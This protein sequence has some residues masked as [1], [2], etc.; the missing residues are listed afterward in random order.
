MANNNGKWQKTEREIEYSILAS[1][2]VEE[3]EPK[4]LGDYLSFANGYN[5]RMSPPQPQT[6]AMR[7]EIPPYDEDR[8]L[9]PEIGTKE[10]YKPI[11]QT[12]T[13]MDKI[14]PED[15]HADMEEVFIPI[16]IDDNGLVVDSAFEVPTISVNKI[17]SGMFKRGLSYSSTSKKNIERNV[18]T[19]ATFD[20]V[21]LPYELG[22]LIEERNERIRSS[23]GHI[24]SQDLEDIVHENKIYRFVPTKTS[25]LVF[26]GFDSQLDIKLHDG[27]E[28]LTPR[29]IL[30]HFGDYR[31]SEGYINDGYALRIRKVPEKKLDDQV[32]KMSSREQ[33]IPSE[34]APGDLLDNGNELLSDAREKLIESKEEIERLEKENE[35]LKKLLAMYQ[36]NSQLSDEESNIKV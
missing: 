31:L 6:Q 22:K 4:I 28:H 21:S 19:F 11:T 10:E 17:A 30:E 15:I 20:F 5:T 25:L 34:K 26:D 23:N 1:K 2:V 35:Q 18:G 12:Q 3:F 9:K 27:D 8:K 36:N 13:Q 24:S 33:N 7:N 29:E 32:R 14:D 16:E